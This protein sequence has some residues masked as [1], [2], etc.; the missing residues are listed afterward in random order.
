MSESSSDGER[1]FPTGT[2]TFLFTDIEG[3]TQLLQ[4]LKDRYATVLADQQQLLRSAF[5]AHNGQVVDT[6]GDSF[7]VAFQR[8]LD[9]VNAAVAAQRALASHAWPEGSTVRVRMGLHT[10]EPTAAGGGYVGIDVHRAAR[11]AAAAHG[12]QVLLS[13]TTHDLVESELS[14]G[15]TLRDLGEHRLKDLRRPKHLY[16]LVLRGLLSEFPPLQTLDTLPNNLPLALTNFIGREREIAEV[17]RLL[18]Q[19]RLL[20]LVGPGGT[21][22]TRLAL[23]VAAELVDAE[24]FKDGVWFVELAPVAEAQLVPQTVASVLGVREASVQS[25]S[26]NLTDY[27][28]SKNLLLLIDNCEHLIEACAQLA[29]TLLRACP[30][31]RILATS[32]EA[33]GIAGETAWRVP[34]LSLPKTRD[35]ASIETLSSYESIRLFIDRALAAQPAFTFSHANA[36]FVVEIC[37][38]LDGIPLAIELAAARVKVLSPQQIAARLDDRFRLL[39]GGSRTALARQQTLRAL[40]DWSH[41]LLPEAE[42][43]LLRRLSVFAGGWTLEA[44]EGVCADKEEG[45]RIEDEIFSPSSSILHPSDILD[46]LVQLVNKSVVTTDERADEMRNRMLETIRQYAQEKLRESGEAPRIRDQHLDYFVEFVEGADPELRGTEQETWLQRLDNDYDNIRAALEWS[47]HRPEVELRLA[48]ALWRFWR[49]RSYFSE[50]RRWL[51]GALARG[52]DAPPL[53]RA[54]ALMGAGSLANY[55]GD[56]AQARV[57]LTEALALSRQAGD[58]HSIATAL[59]LLTHAQ[60]MTGDFDNAQSALD[61]SLAIF[62]ELDDKR[63]MGY[64]YFFMGSMFLAMD[65]L[66]QARHVLEQSLALLRGVGDRWWIGNTLLQLAW[67]INRQGDHERALA[68]F[69]E[70]LAIGRTFEDKRGIAR[71]LLY[72]AEA[73][74]YQGDYPTAH[75]EYVEA[76]TLFQ[77]IGD[78]WWGTVCLEG[79]AA[80]LAMQG[81]PERVAR[82]LGA[83]ERLHEIIGAP[84]LTAYRETRERTLA[85]AN[86][87]LDDATFAQL[88]SEGCALTFEQAIELARSA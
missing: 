75:K 39:T 37:Q 21:G 19:T 5:A 53:A 58:K 4:R 87:Q 61:E 31:V 40:I 67:G 57:L 69:D 15:I 70:V 17:K 44:A 63:G 48:A 12:G 51:E 81:E 50:G 27:L 88:W 24:Q 33:V 1:P 47:S 9:A 13:Q 7:F 64:V 38:R 83:A 29:D 86:A 16:Q 3:S 8:A 14:D 35:S 77:E 28:R 66:V 20:S 78:K 74:F 68:L 84:L 6:Q 79:L 56:Y 42:R 76:L 60:M 36:P 26:E 46:L 72:I 52:L 85:Y 10:G 18:A 65:E 30:H 80:V 82:L 55:Q 54:K 41:D 45:G 11:I 71:A 49:V 25:V 34:T 32:R 23:Q 22:K 43:V 59:N 73:K 62:K 2:V